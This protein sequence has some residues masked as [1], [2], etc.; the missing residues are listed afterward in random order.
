LRWDQ[1][2]RM[3]QLGQFPR[4]VMRTRTRFHPDQAGR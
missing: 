4:P 1:F 2:H 3:P